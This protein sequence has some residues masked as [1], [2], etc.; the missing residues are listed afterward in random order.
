MS[1]VCLT[2]EMLDGFTA[3]TFDPV[4]K[5]FPFY[6]LSLHGVRGFLDGNG[7]NRTGNG[8]GRNFYFHS[9]MRLKHHSV[10]GGDGAK[11]KDGMPLRRISRDTID[12][13]K[14]GKIS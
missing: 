11:E 9:W 14:R 12:A 7:R 5:L 6:N 1:I 8:S 4:S 3:H 2:N 10:S 13:L